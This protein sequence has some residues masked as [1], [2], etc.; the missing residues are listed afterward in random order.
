[1]EQTTQATE[2]KKDSLL[3]P[4]HPQNSAETQLLPSPSP[5]NLENP[6]KS[7]SAGEAEDDRAL[8]PA[9]EVAVIPLERLGV[10]VNENEPLML[11]DLGLKRERLVE[12]TGRLAVEEGLTKAEIVRELG[13]WCATE[14]LLQRYIGYIIQ[15]ASIA[16]ANSL[17]GF[18]RG[19]IDRL[20]G[21]H[22]GFR[23][24]FDAARAF[25]DVRRVAIIDR[26]AEDD[27]KAAQWLLEHDPD[28]R[29]TF[30][31]EEGGGKRV[32]PVQPMAGSVV[33][34]NFGDSA[35]GRAW[36]E[37]EAR[38]TIE[39]TVTEVK[40]GKD[41]GKALQDGGPAGPAPD[42]SHDPA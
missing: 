3:P 11:A 14:H 42:A 27:W 25:K 32:P 19:D 2:L 34:N 24:A 38:K 13:G 36:Q 33:I 26:A 8:F 7:T 5:E 12:Y 1:M 31:P 18:T 10:S 41:A 23:Y 39:G 35:L 37:N 9:R 20:R 30:K 28:T 22:E 17:C 16:M 15:G 4:G 29:P 21:A 40:D 6:E